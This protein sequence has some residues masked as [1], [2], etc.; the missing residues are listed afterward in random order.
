MDN[1]RH[2]SDVF[3]CNCCVYQTREFISF[4]SHYIRYHKLD[5]NFSVACSVGA[6]AYAT[7]NWG[8]FRVHMHRKHPDVARQGRP[9]PR[10][11]PNHAGPRPVG[12]VGGYD[13]DNE[14]LDDE[15]GDDEIGH[16]AN[17]NNNMFHDFHDINEQQHVQVQVDEAQANALFTLALQGKFNLGDSAVDGIVSHATDMIDIHVQAFKE[18]VKQILQDRGIDDTVVDDIPIHNL[19]D[20]VK[21]SSQRNTYYEKRLPYVKPEE[22]IVGHGYRTENGKLEA[23]EHKAYIVPFQKSLM[24]MLEMPEV[25]Y[26]VEH[27]HRSNDQFMRDIC[28]GDYLRNHPLFV[29]NPDALQII[30]NTDDLEVVNPIGTHT[31]THKITVFYYT[32]ANIPPQHRSKLRAIQLLAIASTKHIKKDESLEA[33]LQDFTDT[34]NMLSN[35]GIQVQDQDQV[36]EKVI[37][38]ALVLVAADTLASHWLGG[39]KEGVGFAWKQCRNCECTVLAAKTKFVDS[40]FRERDDRVHRERCEQLKQLSKRAFKYWSKLWGINKTSCLL[41]VNGFPLTTALVQDPMHI[42]LE[43]VVKHELEI[44]LHQFIFIDQLFTL[45]WLNNRLASFCFSYLHSKDKPKQVDKD[46][47][48]H[49]RLKLTAASF[50][51]FCLTLPFLISQKVNQHNFHWRNILSLIQILVLALSPYCLRETATLLRLLIAAHLTEFCRLYP[52]ESV[53]PKMHYMVHL[54]KQLLTYGPLRHHW[55]MRFEGKNGLFKSKKYRSFKNLPYSMAKYHQTSM[56]LQ[57]SSSRGTGGRSSQYLYSGDI[58]DDG[59]VVLFKEKFP[60]LCEEFVE[61]SGIDNLDNDTRVFRTCAVEIHGL[62]YKTNECVIVLAYDEEDVPQLVY[63]RDIIVHTMKKYFVIEIARILSF[64]THT[65][66]YIIEPSQESHVVLFQHL[67]FR[68]PISMY[69]LNGRDA[70]L[71]SPTHTCEML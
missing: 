65:A 38:G 54:P 64:D 6:C 36:G 52:R 34:V 12:I 43:G 22:V 51:T 8:A 16:N 50:L 7:Q 71:V 19:M 13:D 44:L 30:L 46:S 2:D 28:D 47:A 5:P 21:S 23:V 42:L 67:Q 53:I 59:E 37:K 3:R 20:N 68:W 66:S 26:Y 31:K 17:C 1:N 45:G 24:N 9:R 15:S 49:I 41:K 63:I 48:G 56:C 35:D 27:S 40:A 25:K 33:L 57:Q 55:C 11:I 70:V 69:K 60:N 18:S 39:F 4:N 32:L 14:D 29:E 58:V 10:P 61:V 62:K